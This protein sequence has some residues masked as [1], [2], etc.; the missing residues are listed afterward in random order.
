MHNPQYVFYSISRHEKLFNFETK[1]DHV[2]KLSFCYSC[3]N[4]LLQ[5][6]AESLFFGII[7]LLSGFL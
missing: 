7:V 1:I 6:A 5:E 2:Q 4:Y 3:Y